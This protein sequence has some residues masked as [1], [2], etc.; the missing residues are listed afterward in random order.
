MMNPLIMVKADYR[1]MRGSAW[2]IVLLVAFAVAI[3]VA[4]AAQEKALR[5]STTRAAADFD[6][7]IGAAGSATQLV[8]T[9]VYV[10]PEAL[11]LM[12]GEILSSLGKDPRVKAF[13]PIAFG[14]VVQGY[15]VVGTTLDFLTRWGRY[16]APLEG[17]FFATENEAVIGYD[18]AVSLGQEITPA[19]GLGTEP[20]HQGETSPQEIAHRHEG[21]HLRV[22]G[23]LPATGSPWDKAILVPIESVWEIHGFGNGHQEDGVIGVPFNAGTIPPI[24]AVVVRPASIA[25]AYALRSDYR[26]NGLMALFPAEILVSLYRNLGDVRDAMLVA[27]ILNSVL[28]LCAIILL[29]VAI[30]SL[31]RRRYALLRALGA[32]AFYSGLVAWLG[33]FGLI[34]T[35]CLAGLAL[36]WVLTAALSL[37]LSAQTGLDLQLSPDWT[38]TMPALM[39]LMAGS[40]FACLPA[41]MAYRLSLHETLRGE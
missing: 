22:V 10:Q 15:P 20:T 11:P 14:D 30:F 38:Q 35:G 36:G 3:G 17:R 8:M 7:V 34:T 40:L 2:A 37:W 39:L 29:I 18:V 25:G 9:T 6:L 16:E 4:L 19:H 33:A 24:P 26:K 5:T 28:I 27:S 1:A 13:A 32:S 31:R 41:V 21:A 23:R 12:P